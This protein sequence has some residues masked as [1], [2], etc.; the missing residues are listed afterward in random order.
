MKK[1]NI[2]N[3]ILTG[4]IVWLIVWTATRALHVAEFK[5]H[6]KEQ[7]YICVTS[8]GELNVI[9]NEKGAA[10][11]KEQLEYLR[12]NKNL[13]DTEILNLTA[14]ELSEIVDKNIKSHA[15]VF[16]EDAKKFD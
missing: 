7:N 9:V 16:D 10:I 14:K 8:F 15:D 6:L 11:T 4:L 12:N 3:Y 13:S 5:K 1:E 2:K